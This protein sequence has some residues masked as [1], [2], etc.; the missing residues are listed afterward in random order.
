MSD[1][2]T[3]RNIFGKKRI[4]QDEETR[5]NSMLIYENTARIKGY[6]Y[7]AGI[8]EAGRGPLAGPVVAA[9]VVFDEG[10]TIEHVDDSKKLTER[11]RKFLFDIIVAKALSVAVGIVYENDIDVINILNAT[12]LAM[13]KALSGLTVKP[14]IVLI[15]ALKLDG[16]MIK[17]IPIVRGDSL[18]FTIAAA[19][20]IAKVTRDRI[21]D[22]FDTQ[23]PEYGFK[24]HKGYGTPEHI[25]AIRRYG[26]CPIHRQSFLKNIV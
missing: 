20:I 12:K 16:I 13:R 22:E 18:S 3:E 19:S 23:Y 15:D 9:A 14:D 11:Q 17:Q 1:H 7:V 25:E 26:A 24:N 8:D 4:Q 5:L 21:I 10:V 6:K 2:K